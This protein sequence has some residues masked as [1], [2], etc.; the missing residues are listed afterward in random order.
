MPSEFAGNASLHPDPSLALSTPNSADSLSHWCADTGATSHMTLHR[1]WLRNYRPHRAPV[2]LANNSIV[3]SAGIGSVLFTPEVEGQKMCSVEFTN[4]L[5]VPDLCNNL[6]SVLYLTRYKQF[7]VVILETV[8]NFLRS[9]SVL[10]AAA[11][12]A[13][14]SAYLEGTTVPIASA[15]VNSALSLSTLPMDTLLW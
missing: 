12:T 9:G 14:N 4:V 1:H 11:A 13:S 8:M 10:F 15:L 7:S 5:H 3:Y 6:L 2:R